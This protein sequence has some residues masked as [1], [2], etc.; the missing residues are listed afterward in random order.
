MWWN[1]HIIVT[2]TPRSGRL[3]QGNMFPIAGQQHCVIPSVSE[4]LVKVFPF[5]MS[6]GACQIHFLEFLKDS[7]ADL[8][9]NLHVVV[10]LTIQ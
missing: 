6:G 1:T 3:L 9:M 10:H 2:F 8:G 4:P 5:S 7:L